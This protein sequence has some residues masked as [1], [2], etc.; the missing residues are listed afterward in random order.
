MNLTFALRTVPC[1]AALALGVCTPLQAMGGGTGF[2]ADAPIERE[3]TVRP[4][5]GHTVTDAVAALK[6]AGLMN[7]RAVDSIAQRDIH[8]LTH[9]PQPGT[10]LPTLE[11]IMLGLVDSGV[12]A[13]A[14]INYQCQTAEGKTDS[15]WVTGIGFGDW[16]GQQY[17]NP[18]LGMSVAH[19]TSRGQGVVVAILDTGMDTAHPAV[20]G[21]M[22]PGAWSFVSNSA[23]VA[24]AGNNT[25]DDGDGLTDEGVGHGTFVAS[26]VRQVAPDALLLPI[27]VLDSEGRS[28]NYRVAKAM[29]YAIDH[30]AQVINM[31]LGTT[32]RSAGMEEATAE[33]FSKGIAVV[34]AMGNLASDVIREYPASDNKAIGIAAT[35][36]NDVLGAF[37]S[38]GPRTDFC[39][40]GVTRVSGGQVQLG[41]SLIGAVPGGGFAAWQG[42]SFACALASGSV[43]LVRAQH[44]E[45]PSADVG[46]NEIVDAMVAILADSAADISEQNPGHA[47]DVGAGRLNVAAAVAMGPPA[48]VLG[49][50]NGD[51]Q[52]NGE[53][54]G[55][56]LSAW[57]TAQANADLDRDGTVNGSDLGILLS[58]WTN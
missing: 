2:A 19:S 49:D 44:P 48:P 8:L 42:T 54:L 38:Y 17:S 40:P 10:D 14:E 5:P 34:A 30:G 57:Q 12:A 3:L 51:Q 13:W 33:A 27:Q 55:L 9:D 26:L 15:L 16:Y 45:W 52:V 47:G 56:L 36:A 23:L 35:D 22:A 46:A 21:L 39:A 1:A 43:A 25:D 7:I 18:L 28:D 37:S 11:A 53:D 58:C 31:S 50:L 32:Y 24:D 29:F 20:Q 6:Q 4:A 41:Q